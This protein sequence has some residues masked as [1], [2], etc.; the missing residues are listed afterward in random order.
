MKVFPC[1]GK[2]LIALSQNDGVCRGKVRYKVIN[3][4]NKQ[5]A[6]WVL[7]KAKL[8]SYKKHVKYIQ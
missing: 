1:K 3:W 4:N 2:S 8:R 7:A 5:Y 6:P